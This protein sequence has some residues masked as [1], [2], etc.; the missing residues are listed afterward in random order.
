MNL[1]FV[2]LS[3]A[4]LIAVGVANPLNFQIDLSSRR[5]GN[6][7]DTILALLPIYG[8]TKLD[9]LIARRSLEQIKNWFVKNPNNYEILRRG[10]Y[11][12]G[13]ELPELNYFNLASVITDEDFKLLKNM[14]GAYTIRQA[15]NPDIFISIV[16]T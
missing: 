16:V 1:G 10:L 5:V 14:I 9:K 11:S 3:L 15:L 4:S 12:E 8:S 7:Y 2:V 13:I 6:N